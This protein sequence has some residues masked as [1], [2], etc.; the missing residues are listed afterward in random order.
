MMAFET[1]FVEM[2]CYASKQKET[3]SLV[4]ILPQKCGIQVVSK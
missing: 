4:V 1:R 3:N 2:L